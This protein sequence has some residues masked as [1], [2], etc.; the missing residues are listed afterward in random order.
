MSHGVKFLKFIFTSF[1]NLY[2]R[3]GSGAEAALS[4]GLRPRLPQ[5]SLPADQCGGDLQGGVGGSLAPV[6]GLQL[7][8]LRHRPGGQEPGQ[9][10]GGRHTRQGEEVHPQLRQ[11]GPAGGRGGQ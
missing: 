10:G 2:L 5:S 7:H 6:E 4:G 8:L 3:R 9:G 1:H 11:R